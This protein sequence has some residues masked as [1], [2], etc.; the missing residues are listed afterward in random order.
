ML[1]YNYIIF[2]SFSKLQKSLKIYE[3]LIHHRIFG[4]I[5][6]YP[7]TQEKDVS[8]REETYQREDK[9]YKYI[10]GR[11]YPREE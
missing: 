6:K 10:R 11:M 1:R 2:I 7:D 5:S 9:T 4:Y 3:F 8:N